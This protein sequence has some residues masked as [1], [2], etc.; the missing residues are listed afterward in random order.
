M[1]SYRSLYRHSMGNI[2]IPDQNLCLFTQQSHHLLR[3]L[4]L[5]VHLCVLEVHLLSA[6]ET[7]RNGV[8]CVLEVLLLLIGGEKSP[9]K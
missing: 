2:R 5:V 8:V 3:V 1:R 9:T 4:K 6:E 7:G